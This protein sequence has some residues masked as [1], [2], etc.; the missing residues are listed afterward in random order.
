MDSGR[1]RG[2]VPDSLVFHT[3]GGRT[4]YGGGGVLP[5]FIVPI[6][7]SLRRCAS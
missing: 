3:D 7:S 2:D 6:D 4:V 5:D 1:L